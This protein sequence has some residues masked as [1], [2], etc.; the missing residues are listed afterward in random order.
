M[1]ISRQES[2]PPGLTYGMNVEITGDN[3][4]TGTW[5][6]SSVGPSLGSRTRRSLADLQSPTHPRMV[7][8]HYLGQVSSPVRKHRDVGWMTFDALDGKVVP[9]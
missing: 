7:V 3:R 9:R 5:V 8:G 2:Y 4:G 6:E 1:L